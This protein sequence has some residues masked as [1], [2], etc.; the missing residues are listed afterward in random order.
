MDNEDLYEAVHGMV[1][2]FVDAGDCPLEPS[3]VVDLSGSQPAI[4]RQGRG[5]IDF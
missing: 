4:L 3:T 2:L 1:D 5:V